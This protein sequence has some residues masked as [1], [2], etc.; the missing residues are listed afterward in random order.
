MTRT[1]PSLP[2]DHVKATAEDLIHRA[3]MA[4]NYHRTVYHSKWPPLIYY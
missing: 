4:A 3:A 2:T 1:P